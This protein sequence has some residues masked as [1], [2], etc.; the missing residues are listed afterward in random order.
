LVYADNVNR[1]GGRAHTVKKTAEALVVTSI[2]VKIGIE[3]NADKTKYMVLSLDQNKGRSHNINFD[4]T[5]VPFKVWKSSNMCVK[6]T[7]SNSI[8]ED[9]QSRLK[10]WSV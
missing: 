7:E 9:I 4:N 5:V 1:L 6:F 3:V 10:S 2:H 8:Q